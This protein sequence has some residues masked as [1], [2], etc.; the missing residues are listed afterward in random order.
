MDMDFVVDL[1]LKAFVCFC[2]FLLLGATV[3][4]VSE[5]M[6][7]AQT[8]CQ[9]T[10]GNNMVMLCKDRTPVFSPSKTDIY[11]ICSDEHK[12]HHIVNGKVIE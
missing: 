8:K 12:T 7:D 1:G 2:I 9:E 11:V 10:C 3:L 6:I 5:F 4:T